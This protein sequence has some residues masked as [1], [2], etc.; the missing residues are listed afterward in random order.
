M[1]PGCLSGAPLREKS[2]YLGRRKRP[3]LRPPTTL[4]REDGL[5]VY[6]MRA[7]PKPKAREAQK[8]A[9]ISVATWRLIGESASAHKDPTR[10]QAHIKRLGRAI[11]AS[12]KGERRQR[13]EEAGEEA[14]RLLGC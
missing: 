7:S 10:E 12:L 2:E 6:L 8:N 11:N 1:V 5:F 3:P 14:E 4:P 13:T 9:W